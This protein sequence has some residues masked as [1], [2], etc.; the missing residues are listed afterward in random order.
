M[1]Y[2]WTLVAADIRTPHIQFGGYSIQDGPQP[3]AHSE[4]AQKDAEQAKR[5]QPAKIR[6]RL[7]VRIYSCKE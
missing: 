4:D 1:P 7:Y 2:R 5:K 3:Y 6:P